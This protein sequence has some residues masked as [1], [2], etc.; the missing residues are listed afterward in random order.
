MLEK[1][2]RI[3]LLVISSVVGLINPAFSEAP[4]SSNIITINLEKTAG[5]LD[6]IWSK[7]A[8]SDRAI[9]SL[10]E[11][12]RKDLS[13]FHD[14]TGLER[15]RFHGIFADELD[16]YTPSWANP[17]K[18]PNWQNI[19][20]VY[21]GLLERGVRP[22]VELSFMP[23][24]LASGKATFGFYHALTT[25]PNDLAAWGSFISAFTKHLIDR[26]GIDEVRQWMFEVWNEPNLKF[27]WTGTQAQYFEFFKATVN[28]IKSVD[29]KLMVGGPATSSVEWIPEFL[30]YGESNNLPID[31]I[32][33]H[34]YPADN[35]KK[36]FGKANAY[37]VNDVIPAAMNR[38]RKQIDQSK[39][40]GTPLWLTEWSSDSP[41]MIAHVIKGCLG[42]CAAMS[43]WTFTNTYEELGVSPY[44]LKEGD[45]GWGMMAVGG[46]PLPQ[47]NTYK[48]LHRLGSERLVASNGPVLASRRENGASAIAVWNL[49]EVSQPS[50]MPGATWERTVIG[51][52]KQ[53]RLIL[54]GAIPNAS[55]KVSFVDRD[56]G[57]P[58]PEWRRLGSPQYPTAQQIAQIRK[59]A[60]LPEP[61]VMELNK[62]GELIL[63]LPPECLALVEIDA[64][65]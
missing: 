29:S 64:Q 38:V 3:F 26:Y 16:V 35:Q 53:I 22:F 47:F 28:A 9:I 58:F 61:T 4:D 18:E 51:N 50:G 39:Y 52:S 36:I 49:A 40:K 27:F 62:T 21:D 43:Q 20:R 13:R 59:S 45:N 7:S 12:W 1:I 19:D 2:P 30:A 24:N 37:S 55:V 56:R 44:V 6:H 57:S 34:I 48:L 23:K 63:D 8:G 5:P 25:P 46:I 17:T 42:I 33:T 31:F 14:E 65:H 41:A 54:K 15:V 11:Q 10:R 60:E 32:S